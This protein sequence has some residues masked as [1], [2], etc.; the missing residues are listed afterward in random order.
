MKISMGMCGHLTHW[1]L[2]LHTYSDK[3][4]N[5]K[6]HFNSILTVGWYNINDLQISYLIINKNL[7]GINN[8]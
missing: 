6:K 3:K 4:R 7:W 8:I 2:Q 5:I 1:A